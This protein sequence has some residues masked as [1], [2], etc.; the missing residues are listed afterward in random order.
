MNVQDTDA[1]AQLATQVLKIQKRLE[2]V[3]TTLAAS[4]QSANNNPRKV[5]EKE[6]HYTTINEPW[7][8]ENSGIEL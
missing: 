3:E 7:Y 6:P 8:S 5:I 2:V 1:I 4:V